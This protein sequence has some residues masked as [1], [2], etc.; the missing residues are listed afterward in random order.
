MELK[1]LGFNIQCGG[2][3]EER[4]P[5]AL[6]IIAEKDPDIIGFQEVV[7]KWMPLLAPLDEEYDHILQYRHPNS[8]EATPLY[9]KKSVFELVE[10]KHFWLSETPY[11][12]SKG[13]NADY[14]R[15]CSYAALR[16]KASGKLMYFYNTHFDW[17]GNGP[18]ESA[19]LVIHRA[20]THGDAPVF[21]TA[22]FNFAPRSFGWHSMRSWFRDVR[23]DIAPENKQATLHSYQE[24]GEM[25]SLIIDYCFYH[26]RGVKPTAYEVVNRCIDGGYASDHHPVFYAFEVEE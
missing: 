7:P 11:K 13:W 10:E 9:W 18:R 19:Q 21:C 5:R 16:H 26:G 8:E 15:I 3:R 4:A 2:N 14:Y 25:E 17:V 1:I 12:P 6:A 20:E 23:E 22:D 24:R